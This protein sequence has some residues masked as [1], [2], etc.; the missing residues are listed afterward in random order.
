MNSIHTFKQKFLRY[1]KENG[2]YLKAAAIIAVL[3]VFSIFFFFVVEQFKAASF[4]ERTIKTQA[5]IKEVS[6]SP[7]LF[8]YG[9]ICD[10]K[11]ERQK[12]RVEFYPYKT[13]IFDDKHIRAK[14]FVSGVEMET[15]SGMRN[16]TVKGT[17]LRD[18]N[19]FS[20]D[21]LMEDEDG[22]F[23]TIKGK[24]VLF[25]QTYSQPKMVKIISKEVDNA[26]KNIEKNVILPYELKIIENSY[27]SC[28]KD[29]NKLLKTIYEDYVK[30]GKKYGF[31]QANEEFL[32]SP[33]NE[34]LSLERFADEAKALSEM[35]Y[36]Y[37]QGTIMEPIYGVYYAA[38]NK[39]KNCMEKREIAKKDKEP[40]GLRLSVELSE[41]NFDQYMQEKLKR[42]D[43]K[44]FFFDN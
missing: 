40:L 29:K 2:A 19:A 30:F 17:A 24:N 43:V 10:I 26:G 25:L 42:Y 11:Q 41:N 35:A 21:F 5:N 34:Q 37:T 28:V 15:P 13:L 3:S 38:F 33:G 20:V 27:V 9:I 16:F 1:K 44:T 31:K 7:S 8:S 4:L 14:F 6:C 12:G 23:F 18:G 32:S 22:K 39:N 36:R